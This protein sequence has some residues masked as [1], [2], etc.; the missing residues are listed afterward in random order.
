MS[1]NKIFSEWKKKPLIGSFSIKKTEDLN[2]IVSLIKS[3]IE[4]NFR[5]DIQDIYL[6]SNDFGKDLETYLTKKVDESNMAVV[7]IISL[8][9]Y[10]EVL[11]DILD[12]FEFTNLNIV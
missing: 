2:S 3:V 11:Q 10:K 8:S 5:K 7:G 9:Y 6:Q 12:K 4:F 1:L